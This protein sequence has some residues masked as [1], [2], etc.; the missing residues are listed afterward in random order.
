MV[1]KKVSLNIPPVVNAQ[2][3]DCKG[4]VQK[5]A[6]CYISVRPPPALP[7]PKLLF[8]HL[9][10]G[11]ISIPPSTIRDFFASPKT[12]WIEPYLNH[13]QL[14]QA[15]ECVRHS[16]YHCPNSMRDVPL[17]SLANIMHRAGACRVAKCHRYG[18]SHVLWLNMKSGNPYNVK[19]FL[20]HIS[21]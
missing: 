8:L 4:K 1:L 16:L 17:L 9:S 15:L 6:T 20:T 13:Y 7:P 5:N 18:I 12:P 11:L 19:V 2:L 14:D 21:V 3:S 10:L